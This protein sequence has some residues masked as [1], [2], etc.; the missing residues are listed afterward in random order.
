MP[1]TKEPITL[2]GGKARRF[3]EFEQAV[4]ERLGYEPT[5]PE[6][7]GMMMAHVSPEDIRES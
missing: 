2:Y 6:V 1:N 4:E 3:R 5:K 7:V